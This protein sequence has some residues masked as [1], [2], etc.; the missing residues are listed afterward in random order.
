LRR[1]SAAAVLGLFG[2]PGRYFHDAERPVMAIR[3]AVDTHLHAHR[4]SIGR[5][6]ARLI[7]D[8]SPP[9][10]AGSLS[11][12]RSSHR[13]RGRDRPSSRNIGCGA[14]TA[15]RRSLYRKCRPC[16]PLSRCG[17]PFTTAGEEMPVTSRMVG[18]VWRAYVARF[19][20][21]GCTLRFAV[22][23]SAQKS[24]QPPHVFLIRANLAPRRKS[25]KKTSLSD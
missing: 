3:Y 1:Q 5:D 11:Y 17:T 24:R 4:F 19:N 8:R 10:E 2:N 14:S 25:V 20:R 9:K 12:W 18:R 6:L 23:P 21:T 7:A 15:H 13:D 16:S 22:E